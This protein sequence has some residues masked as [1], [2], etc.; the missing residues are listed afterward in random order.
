MP[1]RIHSWDVERPELIAGSTQPGGRPPAPEDLRLVQDFVN[2]LDR[3][4]QVEL[5]DAP[6]GLAAWLAHRDLPGAPTPADLERAL[7][8]REA[9]RALLLLNT[10]GG[11]DAEAARTLER[12]AARAGLAV[13]MLPGGP[14]LAPVAEG[15][16]QALG[17]VVAV[18]V[19]AMLDGRWARL[20]AC[21]RDVCGWAFYDRSPNAQATWCSMQVCGNRVKAGTYYRRR[22]RGA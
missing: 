18:A 4:N 8:L 5:F 13:R 21:P 3:E 9:L 14:A 17:C 12:A 1:V 19:T 2:T 7:A 15:V 22:A 20:K 10:H 16:D 11:V 6:A